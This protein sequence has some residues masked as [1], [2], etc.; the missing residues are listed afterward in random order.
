MANRY[1]EAGEQ[2]AAKVN[3]LF[4]TIAL[5][6]DLINDLQ[7][8]GLHRVWKRR[9]V[10]LAEP[11]PG[12]RAYDLC[13]GTG[14]VTFAL[15]RKGCEA[16]GLDFS[17]EMLAVAERRKADSTCSTSACNF[18]RGDAQALPFADASANIVTISYGLRNLANLERGLDEMRRVL[19][20]GGRAFILDFGKPDNPV[21]RAIYFGYLRWVVPAFGWLFCGDSATHSYI[22]ESLRHYP[23][24]RGVDERLRAAGFIETR[25]VNLLGGIMSINI[26]VKVR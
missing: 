15:A 19:K 14:D 1:F 9:L 4:D 17:A 6:Y 16:T 7:S 18:V 25:I 24:Q 3:D 21:W 5:R 22:L 10:R 8:F 20:P 12:K 13:C 23:G 11:A 2:R 26:G